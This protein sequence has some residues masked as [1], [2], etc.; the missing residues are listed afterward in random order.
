MKRLGLIIPLALIALFGLMAM[1][2]YNGLVS[3]DEQAEKTWGNVETEY[4]RRFDLID[5]LVETVKGYADFEKST[6]VEV[7]QARAAAF[8]AMKSVDENGIEQFQVAQNRLGVAMRGMLGYSEQYPDL[9]ANKNFLELQAQLEGTENRIAFS[10]EKYN[11][12][13]EVYNKKVRK[14]PSNI[15]AG[16]FGFEKRE[17]FSSSEG[18]DVAPKVNF[19]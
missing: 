10:R 2:S 9:K 11:E 8:G 15:M 5:N 6:L 19:K 12:S 18:A 16:M 17:M 3:V 13:V 14:F 7:T 4:Q 1:F